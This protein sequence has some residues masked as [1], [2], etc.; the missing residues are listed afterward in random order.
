MRSLEKLFFIFT[1]LVLAAMP[2]HAADAIP[3]H[4]V[5]VWATED[6]V[7]Q[8]PY[9]FE[10]QALYLGADGMGGFVGGPPP[11]G[12]K[13]VATFDTQ[14]NIIEFDIYEG[15]QRGPQSSITYDPNEGTVDSGTPSRR[16]PMRRRF[17]TFTDEMK[18]ALGL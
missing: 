7:L 3:P 17:D 6:S 4:L 8:G 13:I 12:F 9:L 15:K 1:L 16:Q 5:G 2:I 11:I 14:K 18:K 10:G